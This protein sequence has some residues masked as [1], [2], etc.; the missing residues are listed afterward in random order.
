MMVPLIQFPFLAHERLVFFLQVTQHEN[1][2][3]GDCFSCLLISLKESIPGQEAEMPGQSTYHLS[4]R[5]SNFYL[6]PAP[7]LLQAVSLTY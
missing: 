6:L 2:F 1:V 7:P 3:N 5:P 4:H